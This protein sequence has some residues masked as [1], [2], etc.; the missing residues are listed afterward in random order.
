[1]RHGE[2][3]DKIRKYLS[4]SH[5]RFGSVNQT[6]THGTT[7][8]Q[9][10]NMKPNTEELRKVFVQQAA[11]S[12]RKSDKARWISALWCSRVVERNGKGDKGATQGLA[13]DMGLSVDTVEDLAHAY[14]I[15][16]DLCKMPDARLF[17]FLCRRS[18]WIYYSHFRALY[19]ARKDYDLSDKQTLQILM[20]VY[21]AEGGISSRNISD[22]TRERF[23]K[24][25]SWGYYAR[26][27]ERDMQRLYEAPDA[28][29]KIKAIVKKPML[30]LRKVNKHE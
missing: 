23:G 3:Q 6:N 26:R 16:E 27:V 18:P 30:K 19:D 29:R 24:P 25:K 14:W 4:Q 17:V 5:G 22:H 8:V 1:M 10:S 20:D 12:Y 21:Q 2:P 7:G 11:K 13:T 28:P 9:I 15:F